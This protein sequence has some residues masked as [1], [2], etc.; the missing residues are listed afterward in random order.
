M[1]KFKE[2]V[3]SLYNIGKYYFKNGDRYEGMFYNNN[4]HGKGLFA[5]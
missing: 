2:K 4:V 5:S 3:L 1:A